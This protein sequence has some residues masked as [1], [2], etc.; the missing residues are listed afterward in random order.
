MK[1]VPGAN[2]ARFITVAMTDTNGLLRGQKV[3][4]ASFEGILGA[5]MG[6]SSLTFALDPT[7][8]ILDIPG[9]TDESANFHDSPLI[10]DPAPVRRTPR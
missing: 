8:A 10:A 3:S 5:N 6:L 9:V 2:K 4:R 1:D 7:D